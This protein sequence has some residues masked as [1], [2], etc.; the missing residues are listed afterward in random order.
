M[1]TR[2][3]ER[4]ARIVQSALQGVSLK[5]IA[6]AEGTTYDSVTEACDKPAPT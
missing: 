1:V 6:E 4:A 3:S 5:A 2:D